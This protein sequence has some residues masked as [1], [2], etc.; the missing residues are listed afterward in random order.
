VTT[1]TIDK[2]MVALA[3]QAISAQWFRMGHF[4]RASKQTLGVSQSQFAERA[5]T[6]DI[7]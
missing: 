2:P 5:A 1:F 7:R 3:P 6:G 4:R